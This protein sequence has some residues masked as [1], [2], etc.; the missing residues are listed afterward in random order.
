MILVDYFLNEV[1][2]NLLRKRGEYHLEMYRFFL[3][4]NG[5]ERHLFPTVQVIF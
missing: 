1:Y 5:L 3:T 4:C 2:V